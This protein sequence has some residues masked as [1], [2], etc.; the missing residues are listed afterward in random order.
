M[1]YADDL[2]TI[3]E[4]LRAVHAGLEAHKNGRKDMDDKLATMNADIRA[5]QQV[6]AKIDSGALAAMSGHALTP[7]AAALLNNIQEDSAF[8]HIAARNAGTCRLS[9]HVSIHAALVNENG[10]VTSGDGTMPSQPER[11]GLRGPVLKPLRLLA[12][13]PSRPVSSDSVEFVQLNATGDAAEQAGEGVEKAEIDFEGEL[14]TAPVVTIAGHT[15]ASKQ[16]LADQSALQQ[17]IDRT[18]R[19]KTLARLEDQIINGPG[20]AH[21]IKGLRA[22]ATAFIPTIGQTPA[23]IIGEAL[24]RQTNNGYS[25]NLVVMNPL[26]WFRIQTTKTQTEGEYMFGSPTAPQAPTLWTT[27]IVLAP[28][29]PEGEALTIDTSFT[30]VLD[31]EQPSVLL[32]NSHKDYFTRNLVLILAE[33]RAGLEVADAFAVYKMSLTPPSGN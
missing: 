4:S 32:S 13:L 10:Q 25:P 31:R 15:T 26:D 11:G 14:V 7:I 3:N 9:A 24:V 5:M 16:V 20:G 28:T 33:L 30:T 8:A 22:S 21:K 23:D 12:A 1:S 17:Q 27:Q 29:M 6:V 18:M 19:H 2:N